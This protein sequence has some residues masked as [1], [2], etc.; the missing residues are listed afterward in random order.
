MLELKI[1][2]GMSGAGKSQFLRMLEDLGF[3]TVDHLPLDLLSDF[4]RTMRAENRQTVKAAVVVDVRE[5]NHFDVFF[6]HLESLSPEEVHVEIIFLEAETDVLIRRFR[7][8]RRRH[9]LGNEIRILA[10]VEE[11][12]ELMAPIR[13]I[14]DRKIDT[15]HMPVPQLQEFVRYLYGDSNGPRLMVNV[16]SFGFKY[17]VPRDADFMFDVRFLPNPFYTPEL[18]D[19]TGLDKPVADFIMETAPA[20]EFLDRIKGLLLFMMKNFESRARD[21]IDIAVGC[22]GGQ[23][24]SVFFAEKFGEIVGEAGYCHTVTHRDIWRSGS[25]AGKV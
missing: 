21:N 11:E 4:I 15:T 1:V 3:Y 14:A 7:E 8:T 24:R 19:L 5:R 16:V 13:K 25:N 17:G 20:A 12:R 23:H 22:T 10:A 2:T 18:K 6:H 9:P